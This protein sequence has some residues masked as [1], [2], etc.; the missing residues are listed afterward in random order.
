[1]MMVARTTKTRSWLAICNK[2]HFTKVHSLVHYILYPSQMYDPTSQHCHLQP[3]TMPP[4]SNTL[5]QPLNKDLMQTM[6]MT[7]TN[8]KRR[9]KKSQQWQQWKLY[10]ETTTMTTTTAA[11]SST[12]AQLFTTYTIKIRQN[13]HFQHQQQESVVALSNIYGCQRTYTNKGLPRFIHTQIQS[14]IFKLCSTCMLAT[15]THVCHWH[16][17]D[18]TTPMRYILFRLFRLATETWTCDCVVFAK[19]MTW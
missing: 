1:M 4:V 19:D 14:W 18:R 7:M 13:V 3:I 9:K 12:C 8:K 15:V 10:N 6:K 17:P 2:I 16:K 5:P 11:A